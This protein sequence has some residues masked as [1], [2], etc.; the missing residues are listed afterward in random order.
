M[1]AEHR[2]QKSLHASAWG[3]GS[4]CGATATAETAVDSDVAP[5]PMIKQQIFPF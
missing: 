2:T 4:D 1:A 3:A 5:V